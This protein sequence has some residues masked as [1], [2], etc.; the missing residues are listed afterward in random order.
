[1]GIPLLE[2]I[3]GRNQ[4]A[5]RNSILIG[6]IQTKVAQLEQ[7]K[8]ELAL[9]IRDKVTLATLDFEQAA[10]EFQISQE[11]ALRSEQQHEIFK[12][13]YRFGQQ[14]TSQYLAQQNSLD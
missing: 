5:Q 6:D 10:R 4:A 7:A 1:M 14:S 13:S 9:T 3:T 2:G 12:L 8:A 11:I